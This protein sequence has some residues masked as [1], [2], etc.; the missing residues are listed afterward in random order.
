[1]DVRGKFDNT[2]IGLLFKVDLNEL[3]NCVYVAPSSKPW[4]RDVIEELLKKYG[5]NKEVRRSGI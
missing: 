1:M 5:L 4:Y 3:I 2:P